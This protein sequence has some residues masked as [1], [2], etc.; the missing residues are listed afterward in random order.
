MTV[1]ITAQLS[2]VLRDRF[3]R[4]SPSNQEGILPIEI[5]E[6]GR[7]SR[8]RTYNLSLIKRMLYQ[9]C[10][11]TLVRV[12]SS[13]LRLLLSESSGLLTTFTLKVLPARLKQLIPQQL[14]LCH[15]LSGW[16]V[17]RSRPL[18]SKSS[19]LLLSYTLIIEH[20]SNKRLMIA[21]IKYLSDNQASYHVRRIFPFLI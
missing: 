9:L 2:L 15:H 19:T 10:Y 4:S 13:A 14:P 5:T 16:G 3:E 6:H 21:T 17:L 7:R 11:T 12:R 18:L 8:D 20:F 1:R